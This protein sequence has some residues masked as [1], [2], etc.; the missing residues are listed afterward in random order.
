MKARPFVLTLF[1]VIAGCNPFDEGQVPVL[2]VS[3]GLRPTIAWTPEAAYELRVYAGG[4]DGDRSEVI[5]KQGLVAPVWYAKG[6]GGYEN[7]LHSPVTYGVPPPGSE[8]APAPPLT[9]VPLRAD[10]RPGRRRLRPPTRSA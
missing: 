5:E 2:T 6:P 7:S 10:R 1:L 3:K 8:V 9:A 4:K